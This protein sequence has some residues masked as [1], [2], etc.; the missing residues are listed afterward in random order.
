LA[1]QISIRKFTSAL[2]A[3]KASKLKR[4]SFN[5]F[6]QIVVKLRKL[7]AVNASFA[8]YKQRRTKKHFFKQWKY[9]ERRV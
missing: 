2:T 8:K 5:A 6:A 7:R 3:D 4:A 9:T 1:K